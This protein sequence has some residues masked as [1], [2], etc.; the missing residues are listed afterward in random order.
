MPRSNRRGLHLPIISLGPF[1]RMD[2]NPEELTNGE[3]KDFVTVMRL[4]VPLNEDEF[5]Q[6]DYQTT[7]AN[8]DTPLII[9][10]YQIEEASK[11]PI[12]QLGQGFQFGANMQ[13][14]NLPFSI[15]T[16]NRGKYPCF[17]AQIIFPIRLND[18]RS[19][20]KEKVS[21]KNL[22]GIYSQDKILA[23]E[24]LNKLFSSQHYPAS[25][26]PLQ[27][28]DVTNFVEQYFRKDHQTPLYQHL[29]LLDSRNAFKDAIVEFLGDELSEHASGFSRRKE[30]TEIT[31]EADLHNIVMEAI[32]EVLKH[33]VENRSWIQA[34]WNEPHKSICKGKSITI[35]KRP[36]REP[37]IQPTLQVLLYISLNPLGVH[38][39][40]ETGEGA[41]IL[42]FKCLYTTKEGTPLRVPVEFKLA[43]NKGIE[44]GLN[45][46]LPAYLT[47]NNSNHGTFLVM[48]FKDEGGIVFKKPPKV[49]KYDMLAELK[50]IAELILKERGFIIT[51]EI[52]DASIKPPASRQ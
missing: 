2:G 13:L 11:D 1:E 20:N 40:R 18:W 48:W 35:P 50:H 12:F 41:G 51:I 42:D 8:W 25:V 16:D 29:T 30:G 46:Q 7:S 22:T 44:H 31:T 6:G 21:Q 28:E 17:Y 43:H 14:Q 24:V 47:A 9:R 39:E 23:L 32:T 52:I 15:F 33:H 38:V 26:R 34:F 36:K 5:V 4:V 45:K 10:L 49:T 37:S 27:Y 19:P 3:D